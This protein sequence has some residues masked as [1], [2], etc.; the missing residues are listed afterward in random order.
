MEA[1]HR[2]LDF[3]LPQQEQALMALSLRTRLTAL[4]ALMAV[5]G[6]RLRSARA[7]DQPVVKV[8][9]TIKDHRFAPSEIRVPAGKAVMLDIRN[10]DATS[11]EFDSS[12]LRSRR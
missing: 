7:D 4:A 9:V 10:E 5:G 2:A 3:H 12:S 1:D 8:E 11:E 6:A